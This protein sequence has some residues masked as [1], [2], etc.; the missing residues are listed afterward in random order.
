M[1]LGEDSEVKHPDGVHKT[2]SQIRRRRNNDPEKVSNRWQKTQQPT[3]HNRAILGR[4]PRKKAAAKT[5]R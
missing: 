4:E 2:S 5:E 3:E 1:G